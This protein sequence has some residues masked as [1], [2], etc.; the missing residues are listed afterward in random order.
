LLVP[1]N[2]QDERGDRQPT[3][4]DFSGAQTSDPRRRSG[5]QGIQQGPQVIRRER[6]VS[7]ADL[8]RIQGPFDPLAGRF[9][10]PRPRARGRD[11]DGGGDDRQT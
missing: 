7:R 8:V 1:Q 6:D 10:L 9:I 2:L 4:G 11:R 5:S 3:S